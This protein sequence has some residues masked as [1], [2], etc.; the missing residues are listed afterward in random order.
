MF[1][2][3]AL[4]I[5][6]TGLDPKKDA[7]IEIGA[8]KYDGNQ[9]VE[10]W[11]SLINPGRPIPPA[12]TQLTGITN[13]DV[14]KAPPISA[15]IQD[16][17]D[18]I[19][20]LPIIGHNISFD[21][22]FLSNHINLSNNPL[23]DTFEVASVLMPSATRYSLVSLVEALDI[24]VPSHHRALDDAVGSL[25]VCLKLLEKSEKLPVHLLAEIVQ[26]SRNIYWDGSWFF[27]QVLRQ[28]AK[29]P[30]SARKTS[31]SDYGVFFQ[32]QDEIL[33][34]PLKA[35][36]TMLP[37]DLDEITEILSP[38]GLFSQY[39]QN[40][41]T[42]NEQIEMLQAVADA[43]TNSRHLMVEAGT[44]IGKSYAYLVPAALWAVKN[45]A[46]VVIS[47]NTLNLQD[48]LME[49]D[50]PDVS[51]ALGIDLRAAVLKGRAN[52]LCPRRLKALRH[53]KPRDVAELRV[54][55]KVL[56]W[57][58]QGGKGNRNEITLTTPA[59]KDAWM[60][61]SA[62]DEMC[63][64]EVCVGR[65]GGTCPYFRARQKAIGSH[66]LIVNHALLLAD[67]ATNN[68]VLPEYEYLIIDEAHHMED[69]T[70][71]AL[72]FSISKREVER[73][74]RELGGASSGLLGRV[75]EAFQR[76]VKPSERAA[77][78]ARL[79]DVADLAFRA[80]NNI[81]TFFNAINDFLEEVREGREIGEYGQKE[82][83]VPATHT[84]PVWSEVEIAWDGAAKPVKTLASKLDQILQDLVDLQQ[85]PSEDEDVLYG[86]LA[87]TIRQLKDIYKFTD[88]MV[89]DLDPNYIYWIEIDYRFR[90]LMLNF[91]PLHIGTMMENH[92]WHQKECV[93]LTSA[94]L[95]A[96]AQFDYIR[97]RLNADEADELI[98]GSPFDYENSAMLFLPTDM[99]EPTDYRGYQQY[100]TRALAQTAIA[101]SGRMLV[102]FTSYNQ[103]KQ[104]SQYLTPILAKHDIQVLE[105]GSGASPS[106]LLSAFKQAEKAVLLGTRS[107]WEGVDVPGEAL[108]V[109]VITKLPFDVPIDPIIA[110]RAETF[111]NPFSEYTLPEA[112]LK[113]RQGFG[114]LI[115]TQYDRGVVA[116]L[117]RR[118]RTKM[119]GPLFLQSLPQC[120]MVETAVENLPKETAR[121]LNL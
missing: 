114:R 107:F 34:P 118:V 90:K 97:S 11:D 50:I 35:N 7:I 20:D 47:T 121:W 113:F 68:R 59:D 46:R 57:L 104:V 84:M 19:G 31:Q 45:N 110:A 72:S 4:D 76:M 60:H 25:H 1:P 18:F 67:V 96:N 56:V 112:I 13:D 6:T 28:R 69:A 70:T 117:D 89:F 65:M 71:N 99:P 62:Q 24:A 52:Y 115:R 106:V 73:V 54:L 14:R 12:I 109:L 94:T 48:Q 66:I 87:G 17:A 92:I 22:A 29:E 5:E 103:L 79:N 51:T 116:I 85:G 93:I 16:L 33:T 44:G 42:R 111:E 30:V 98:M 40:F 83:V 74:F 53:R 80:E 27:A 64:M 100:L 37:L 95:T 21:V 26:A 77:A 36:D 15:I 39:M 101:S 63:N 86:D 102:L 91:A 32:N 9:I 81:G 55:G 23:I 38:G 10:K 78:E 49:K 120:H 61:L 41:E 105:Q 75:N 43:I 119:Y 58:E 88:A 3:I 2:V 82:R 108:S 8:A